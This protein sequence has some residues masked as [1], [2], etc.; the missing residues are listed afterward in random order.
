MA[1]KARDY[2]WTLHVDAQWY[3]R[4]PDGIGWTWADT[5]KYVS[6]QLEVAPT[7]GQTHLQGYIEFN[8]PTTLANAKKVFGGEGTATAREVHLEKRKGSRDQARDYSMKEDTREEG[9]WEYGTW[10]V[11]A[12]QGARSDLSRAVASVIARGY[13]A[14][15][16]DPEYATTVVRN[17]R[18]LQELARHH[19]PKTDHTLQV[20]RP[21]QQEMYD[22]LKEEPDD[23][24]VWWFFDEEGGKG[25]TAFAKHC[26]SNLG[27]FYAPNG[28]TADLAYAY[29]GQ[30]IVIFDYSRTV[31]ERINYEVL[32]Q[33]KNG[34]V[35]SSKYESRTR[36]FKIPHVVCFSNSLP[37]EKALSADRWRIKTL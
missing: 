25:K 6:W 28:K 24:H 8:S 16:S 19:E 9:P 1:G 30:R 22:I 17:Y 14:T 35:F 36:V 32:E 15:A 31:Q 11:S 34:M 4:Y 13:T 37:D 5:V 10:T 3:T 18:G 21:W 27:A 23:R 7:T 20:L 33:L 26:V 2:C 29:N 12:G